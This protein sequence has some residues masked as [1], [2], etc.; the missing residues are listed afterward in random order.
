MAWRERA[1][2]LLAGMVWVGGS[3]CALIVGIEDLSDEGQ[4]GN[5]PSSSSSAGGGASGPGGNGGGPPVCDGEVGVSCY[6]GPA[7][8]EGIGVCAPGTC[9]AS[10][11]C[12][13]SSTPYTE[14]CSTSDDE[15][16][17]NEPGCDGA[18]L[19]SAV[20]RGPGRQDDIHVA[21]DAGGSVLLAGTFEGSFVI[22]DATGAEGPTLDNTS[23]QSTP[24]DIWMA[25]LDPDGKHVW[26]QRFGDAEDQMVVAIDSYGSNSFV[27][28]G[29]FSGSLDMGQFCQASAGAESR[30][31]V[32]FF[33]ADGACQWLRAF[34]AKVLDA[35][36]SEQLGP[37]GLVFVAGSFEGEVLFG[38]DISA[39]PSSSVDGFVVTIDSSGTFQAIATA[40]GDGIE[41]VTHLETNAGFT[42]ALGQY[43]SGTASVAATTLPYTGGNGFD[44]FLA[45]LEDRFGDSFDRVV[46]FGGPSD[47]VPHGVAV[48]EDGAAIVTV[49]HTGGIPFPTQPVEGFGDLDAVLVKY[50]NDGGGAQWILP[51]QAAGDQSQT[52]VAVDHANQVVFSARIRGSVEI[53]GPVT[54]PAA[55][56]AD[57]AVVHKVLPDGPDCGWKPTLHF[58]TSAFEAGTDVTTDGIGN[59]VL[60]G[61]YNGKQVDMG[62][63]PGSPLPDTDASG[64][65]PHD[66]FI[67]KRRP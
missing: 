49:D 56:L 58:G 53:C 27:I 64:N 15:T 52:A 8:T 10:G 66:L 37:A 28:A 48:D 18:P 55:E 4:G 3:S 19:W 47:D 25:K 36:A 42:W 32:A 45:R 65:S 38:D 9:D 59:V 54:A 30:G 57:D 6:D 35:A 67:T 46:A 62:G 23:G 40:I 24:S 1:S 12:V 43:D 22:R 34:P 16:C 39:G 26:S 50:P 14:N 20:A 51:M 7:G 2:L 5:A 41:R 29:N 60:V 17:D 21:T 33:D 63:G 31:Y 11:D 44:V 61:F 13:G